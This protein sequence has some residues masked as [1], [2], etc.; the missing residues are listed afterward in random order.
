MKN[1]SEK[2]G[3]FN[4]IAVEQTIKE[5]EEK[6]G[7]DNAYYSKLKEIIEKQKAENIVTDSEY[8]AIPCCGAANYWSAAHNYHLVN[9]HYSFFNQTFDNSVSL[10]YKFMDFL[11]NVNFILCRESEICNWKATFSQWFLRFKLHRPDLLNQ[12]EFILQILEAVDPI[13]HNSISSLLNIDRSIAPDIFDNAVTYFR[14]KETTYEAIKQKYA[15]VKSFKAKDVMDILAISRR[16]LSR[17]VASGIIIIDSTIN[18]KYRYNKESV[19]NILEA[20]K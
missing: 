17:Y 3:Y 5:Y 18:G 16:T 8:Q 19:F 13:N 15:E 2:I 11:A 1:L 20:K 6:F 12:G 4:T 9:F 7:K 14:T 10:L